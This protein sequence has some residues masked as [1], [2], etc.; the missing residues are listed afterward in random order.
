MQPHN[1]DCDG[2]LYASEAHVQQ[3]C[4]LLAYDKGP[5]AGQAHAIHLAR[6]RAAQA[7]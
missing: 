3:P 4:T 7:L 6:D 1:T 2:L 5:S